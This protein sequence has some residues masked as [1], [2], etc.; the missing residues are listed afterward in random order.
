M[1][2]LSIPTFFDN[3]HD[4]ILCG[5]ERQLLWDPASDNFGVNDKSLRD[6]LKSW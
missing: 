5:H 6:I 3:S 2:F 1:S 4:D